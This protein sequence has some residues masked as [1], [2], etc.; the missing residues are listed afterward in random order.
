MPPA[1]NDKTEKKK[2]T[3][4]DG[5]VAS[6]NGARVRFD[7]IDMAILT[8]LQRDSKITNATLSKR[9]GISPPSTLE[10]VKK[11]EQSGIIKGYVALID[12]TTVGKSITAIVSVSLTKHG[13]EHL[14]AFNDAV[15]GFDEVLDC[16]HIAGE[17]DFILRVLTTD[18]ESYEHF[19]VHSLSAVGNIA[20]VR[21]SFCMSTVKETTVIPL[22]A[23]GT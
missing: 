8:Q 12:P 18:M 6:R 19:V 16:W 9:V 10:R 2:A 3:S 11:L 21:T 1:W 5:K 13:V 7:K 17:D 15:E 23:A 20:R 22:D 4:G 14:R